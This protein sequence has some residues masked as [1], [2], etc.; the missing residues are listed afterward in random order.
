MVGILSDL[1]VQTLGT[2]G[3]FPGQKPLFSESSC[4]PV[5]PL[6]KGQLP[7][8]GKKSSLDTR[9]SFSSGSTQ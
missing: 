7:A 2:P 8:L 3:G 5:I 1:K 6:P 9:R 4:I